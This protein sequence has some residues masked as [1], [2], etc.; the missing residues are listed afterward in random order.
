MAKSPAPSPF[1][2]FSENTLTILLAGLSA[3][4]GTSK[5]EDELIKVGFEYDRYDE[6]EQ[7]PIY[8]KRK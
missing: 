1:L 6:E 8:R 3:L 5:E 4:P 7:V 2:F